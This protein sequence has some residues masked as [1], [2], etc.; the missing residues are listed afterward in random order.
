MTECIRLFG[1]GWSELNL[2]LAMRASFKCEYCGCDLLACFNNYNSWQ[3]DHIH[4][5]SRGGEDKDQ[6]Y[7]VCC[8]ACNFLKHGAA[9]KGFDPQQEPREDQIKYFRGYIF[10]KRQEREDVELARLRDLRKSNTEC[11]GQ[12]VLPPNRPV[13]AGDGSYTFRRAID[14]G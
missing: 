12:F 5:K 11:L 3:R 13:D 10:G 9:P 6:N 2:K 8:K 1:T 4:A 14:R 7:A